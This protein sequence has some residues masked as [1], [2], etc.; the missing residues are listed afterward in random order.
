[1]GDRRDVQ[2][3]A[4][5]SHHQAFRYRDPDGADAPFI[6][7]AEPSVKAPLPDTRFERTQEYTVRVGNCRVAGELTKLRP[8]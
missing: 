1:M 4:R 3:C 8:V 6:P 5:R 7:E 2:R